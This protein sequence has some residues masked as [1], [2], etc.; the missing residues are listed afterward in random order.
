VHYLSYIQRNLLLQKLLDYIPL[1]NVMQLDHYLAFDEDSEQLGV[2]Y[3]K[4]NIS[5]R[6]NL[7][8]DDDLME[9]IVSVQSDRDCLNLL[10]KEYVGDS[11]L[12][13]T[14]CTI[15]SRRDRFWQLVSFLEDA[16]RENNPSHQLFLNNTQSNAEGFT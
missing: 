10:M 12:M 8:S 6:K 9:R 3:I 4:R 7:I 13:H 5:I 16:F 2:L 1:V 15:K 11:C 14:E